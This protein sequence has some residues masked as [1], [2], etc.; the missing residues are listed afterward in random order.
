[1]L[2]EGGSRVT[3]FVAT[4]DSNTTVEGTLLTSNEN[5]VLMRSTSDPDNAPGYRRTAANQT[6]IFEEPRTIYYVTRSSVRGEWTR[7]AE[8]RYLPESGSKKRNFQLDFALRIFKGG[9][10][11]LHLQVGWS[12]TQAA[13]KASRRQ[14]SSQQFTASSHAKNSGSEG[15]EPRTIA[16]LWTAR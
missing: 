4:D 9:A 8:A 11:Q 5:A 16:T 14:P 7:S 6:G 13:S 12:G 1:M 2:G 15:R 3:A 10:L